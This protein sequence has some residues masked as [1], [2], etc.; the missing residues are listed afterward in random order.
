MAVIEEIGDEE[1]VYGSFVDW[2][3]VWR[4]TLDWT[5]TLLSWSV[6]GFRGF[7]RLDFLLLLGVALLRMCVGYAL[8]WGAAF[9]VIIGIPV[10]RV[11][12]TGAL[13]EAELRQIEMNRQVHEKSKDN[14]MGLAGLGGLGGAYAPQIL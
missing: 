10:I 13:M 12:D 14:A 1:K 3:G 4:E 8:W 5:R 11:A 6:A 9:T 2:R 7:G